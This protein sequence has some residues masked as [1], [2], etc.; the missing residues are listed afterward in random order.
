MMEI[1]SFHL[2]YLKNYTQ[3]VKKIAFIITWRN[4]FKQS[5]FFSTPNW[6]STEILIFKWLNVYETTV[7]HIVMGL[8]E[9]AVYGARGG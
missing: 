8:S 9:S 3:T 4:N 1:F 2:K 6:G 5:V 7:N